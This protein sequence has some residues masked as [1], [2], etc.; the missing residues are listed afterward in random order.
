M[1]R[2]PQGRGRSGAHEN[3]E[4]IPEQLTRVKGSLVFTRLGHADFAGK[5]A[6]PADTVPL[7]ARKLGWI[8]HRFTR[9]HVIASRPMAS[10]AGYA[11]LTER[12][13]IIGV[14]SSWNL[15]NRA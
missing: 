3:R 8:H 15:L 4:R 1:A 6:L 7:G 9:R 2:H 12:G 13:G 5:M 14:L 10:F 11:T